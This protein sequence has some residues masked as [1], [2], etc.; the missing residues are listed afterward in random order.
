MSKQ[1]IHILVKVI[2]SSFEFLCFVVYAS[3]RFREICI[4]WNNLKNATN[5]HDEPWIIVGNFNEVL[6]DKFGD[7][8]INL[9][10]SLL[11]KECL[12][13]CNIIDMGFEGPRF[14]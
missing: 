3:P 5:L 9:N 4:Q 2:S 8:A 6:A 13:Y 10:M 7:Q 11:F 1:E 14:T 12:D